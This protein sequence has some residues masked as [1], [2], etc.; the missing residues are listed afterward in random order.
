MQR[1]GSYQS[2]GHA[3]DDKVILWVYKS[4]RLETRKGLG[5]DDHDTWWNMSAVSAFGRVHSKDGSLVV[6][7]RNA[8]RQRR[9]ASAI[10]NEFPG[11][12]FWVWGRGWRGAKGM[13]E[14]WTHISGAVV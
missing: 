9:L 8:E 5:S 2:F 7:S 3:D 6:E 11:V 12:R 13:Q 10:V 14:W 1:P 4:G